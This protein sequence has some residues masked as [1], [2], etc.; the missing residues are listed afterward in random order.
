MSIA[1][2]APEGG[3]KTPEGKARSAQNARR[4]G[5]RACDFLLSPDEDTAE[6][7]LHLA[8]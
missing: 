7:A 5:L 1:A 2:T 3:P 4:H 6:W 8:T